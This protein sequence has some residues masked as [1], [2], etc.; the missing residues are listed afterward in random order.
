MKKQTQSDLFNW[1]SSVGQTPNCR[2]EHFFMALLVYQQGRAYELD[3]VWAFLLAT[4]EGHGLKK[5]NLGVYFRNTRVRGHEMI[6]KEKNKSWKE[7][8][9][10]LGVIGL[11]DPSAGTFSS[12]T[13]RGPTLPP[14]FPPSRVNRRLTSKSENTEFLHLHNYGEKTAGHL[15]NWVISD[16][17]A[18]ESC[19]TDHEKKSFTYTYRTGLTFWEILIYWEDQYPSPIWKR[20]WSFHLTLSL[21]S[22]LMSNYSFKT[23]LAFWNS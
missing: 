20:H 1:N 15:H 4:S 3:E 13:C 23:F 10:F 7:S 2:S 16:K 14:S 5:V 19:K 12:V 18:G 21:K 11:I 17:C 6:R 22:K 8:K 9:I